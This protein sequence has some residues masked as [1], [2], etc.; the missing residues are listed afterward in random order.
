[1][2]DLV[3][4]PVFLAS[5]YGSTVV[6]LNLSEKQ[7][8]YHLET[9]KKS[10]SQQQVSIVE[11]SFESIPFA[12]ATFDIVWSQDALLH[13]SNRMRVLEE[14]ARVSKNG[15]DFVFTDPM[16]ADDCPKCTLQPILDRLGLRSLASPNFYLSNAARLGWI[17]MEFEDYTPQF[18]THYT[19]ILEETVQRE[20][21]LRDVI[22]NEF[23][24]R[25]KMGLARWIKGGQKR[26]LVW[27]VF[28][29]RI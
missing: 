11:G 7:N 22:S 5:S 14:V 13:G 19:R 21:E 9:N 12:D 6:A 16:Q 26:H 2:L 20:A 8:R 17:D 29:F 3:E 23:I 15:G 24:E 1:M 28:H 4:R 27:G 18:V 10:D 25:T